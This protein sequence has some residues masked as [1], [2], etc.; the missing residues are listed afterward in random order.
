MAAPLRGQTPA[1]A[2]VDSVYRTG[3]VSRALGHADLPTPL[4][5]QYR[6]RWTLCIETKTGT[7]V[8]PLVCR[9]RYSGWTTVTKDTT[10]LPAPTNLAVTE[11]VIPQNSFTETHYSLYPPR[12]TSSD[13][14]FKASAITSTRTVT[15]LSYSTAV[16]ESVRWEGTFTEPQSRTATFTLRT[17]DGSRVYVDGILVM[18]FFQPQAPTTYTKAVVLGAGAHTLRVDYYN[19]DASGVMQLTW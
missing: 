7:T 15:S 19:N 8:A 18:D 4:P 14:V 10:T 5:D 12:G 17:D 16:L 13:T 6:Y 11:T 3:L 1:A 9:G 2:Y